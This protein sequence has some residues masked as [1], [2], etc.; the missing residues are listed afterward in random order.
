[1]NRYCLDKDFEY[2]SDLLKGIEFIN[3]NC[4]IKDG[5]IKIKSGYG[6]DGCSPTYKILF[7][8]IG[9]PDGERGLDGIPVGYYP[10]LVHDCLCQYKLKID[11]TKEKVDLIFYELLLEYGMKEWQANL[12]YRAV[13]LFG[14]RNF[15]GDAV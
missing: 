15:R 13:K 9:T 4:E 5:I 11:I 3:D 6:W 7:L 12:Y 14:P 2:K 8:W 10:S 1:M